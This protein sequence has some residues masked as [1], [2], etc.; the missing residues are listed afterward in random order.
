VKCES[1][2][3]ETSGGTDT[4]SRSRG[5]FRSKQSASARSDVIVFFSAANG[6]HRIRGAFAMGPPEVKREGQRP[7]ATAGRIETVSPSFTSVS[8]EPR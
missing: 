5:I 6:I 1:V 7:P 8:S 4:M 3:V 2:I